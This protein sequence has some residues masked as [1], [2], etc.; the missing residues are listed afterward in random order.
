MKI[1]RLLTDFPILQT[2]LFLGVIVKQFF[3]VSPVRPM[4]LQEIF[5][6]DLMVDITAW[7]IQPHRCTYMTVIYNL[8][9]CIYVNFKSKQSSQLF[10]KISRSQ[11]SQ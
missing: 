5:L 7:K 8:N 3:S 1:Q 2:Y 11:C 9:E 10:S 4:L 6:Y